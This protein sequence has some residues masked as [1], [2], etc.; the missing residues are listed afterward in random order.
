MRAATLLGPGELVVEQVPI[1]PVGGGEVLV[2]VDR[3]GVCGTDVEFFTGEMAYLH[4]GH[5]SY[6]MRLGHEW[7]GRVVEVGTGV[8]PEWVGRRVTGDTM[9]GD[10]TC[11]LCQKGRQ[12]LCEQRQ[13]IGVRGRV[14]A[15]AE[16]LSVP[17]SCLHPLPDSVDD[18]LGALVEPGGNSLRAAKAAEVGAGDRLLVLGPGTIGLLVAFFARAAGAEVHLMGLPG[19]YLD[20]ASALGFAGTW[21][22]ESLPE[23]P[24]DA[25]VDSS[26]SA[27]LPARAVELVEPGG[28]VVLI[29]LAGSPSHVDT[30]QLALR[31]I[32][33]VGLLSASPALSET[34]DAFASGTVNPRPIVA[35]TVGLEGVAAVL[36]GERPAGSGA[37]PKIHVDPRI[38]PS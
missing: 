21:T 36:R 33:A 34:I 20:F 24:F 2:A 38:G 16:Y 15:L 19:K 30:R 8:S 9:H 12:H 23:V 32:T 14:G 29:G 27:A 1:P 7:C 37:G 28:R 11:R 17:E 25:V 18:T 4:S 22:E 31:D 35:A 10:G 26:T 3:V 13:E 5:A 6:P